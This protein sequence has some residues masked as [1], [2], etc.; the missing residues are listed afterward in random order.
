M[1]ADITCD[2]CGEDGQ[3][4]SETCGGCLESSWLEQQA[5][6][7]RLKAIAFDAFCTGDGRG[8]N[9]TVEGTAINPA[10]YPDEWPETLAELLEQKP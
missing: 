5:E 10:E 4:P 8:H 1:S 9:D 6:I 7:E 3:A 2:T